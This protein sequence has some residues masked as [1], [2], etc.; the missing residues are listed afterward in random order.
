MN[1]NRYKEAKGIEITCHIQSSLIKLTPNS[2]IR[3]IDDPKPRGTKYP[4]NL[5]QRLLENINGVR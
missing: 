5:S 3:S 1:I 2:K 4:K